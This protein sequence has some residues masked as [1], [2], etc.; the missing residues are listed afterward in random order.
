RPGGHPTAGRSRADR[1]RTRREPA[2]RGSRSTRDGGSLPA[3][4]RGVRLHPGRCRPAGRKGPLHGRE[5]APT[6]RPRPRRPGGCRGWTS[7][8]GPRPSARWPR[9]RAAGPGPRFGDR[10]GI[11][12]PSDRGARPTP[13]RT[14]A[15]AGR[16]TDTPNGSRA[17]ARRGGPQA[18]ARHQG[19]PRAFAPRR[20]HRY[21]V[22]QRRRTRATLRAPDRRDRVTEEA[23]RSTAGATTKGRTKRAKAGASDYTAASIQVLEGLEA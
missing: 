20:P 15:G 4:H 17:R 3:A 1:A 2:T 14:E 8:R 22:L 10:P 7:D 9:R 5:H 12:G 11:V 19:E 18:F 21:R 16:T 23:T 13:A 6:P